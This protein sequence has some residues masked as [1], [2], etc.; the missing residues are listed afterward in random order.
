MANYLLI[1][2]FI[3]MGDTL[4]HTARAILEAIP[5]VRVYGISPSNTERLKYHKDR[6]V[7]D[8]LNDHTLE[9][10]ERKWAQ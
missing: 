5:H 2:N 4:S 6:F 7:R 3:T 8:L 10:W 9:K 1:N